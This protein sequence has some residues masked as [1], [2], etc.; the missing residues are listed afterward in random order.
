MTLEQI[1]S[2]T[3][4]FALTE[5]VIRSFLTAQDFQMRQIVAAVP[6]VNTKWENFIAENMEN[7][8]VF[9]GLTTATLMRTKEQSLSMDMIA[10][11]IEK[12]TQWFF[13][14]VSVA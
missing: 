2:F 3:L 11:L 6:W 4:L 7:H 5:A 8:S 10:F 9:M 14:T 13:A 12:S 1:L